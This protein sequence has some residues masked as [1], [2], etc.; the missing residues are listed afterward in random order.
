MNKFLGFLY[1]ILSIFN[2]AQADSTASDP[3]TEF[4]TIRHSGQ[5]IQQQINALSERY[6]TDIKQLMEQELKNPPPHGE[7][8]RFEI[9]TQTF[10]DQTD[11]SVKELQQIIIRDSQIKTY[12]QQYIRWLEKT[13]EYRFVRLYNELAAQFEPTLNAT[14]NIQ[15]AENQLQQI[16]TELNLQE[17]NLNTRFN[18][19]E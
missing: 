17:K 1:V 8:P 9:L 11:K 12:Q 6:E 3:K 13:A 2:Y 14:E 4:I 10:F 7:K 15:A 18:I 16:K 19:T 5:H